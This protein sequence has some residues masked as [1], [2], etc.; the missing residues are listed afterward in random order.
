MTQI[1]ASVA[2]GLLLISIPYLQKRRKIVY[3]FLVFLASAFH[4][5]SILALTLCLFWIRRYDIKKVL[6]LTI[7]LCCVFSFFISPVV[8]RILD[9]IPF[10]PIRIKMAE[11]S[12]HDARFSLI[13]PQYV[14]RVL[15]YYFI[16]WKA[17]LIS[18]HNK[19]FY[20]LVFIDA[21]ALSIY[22]L[23]GAFPI[24]SGRGSE[25]LGVVEIILYP[26]AIYCFKQKSV[27]V[28]VVISIAVI[29]LI[30]NITVRPLISIS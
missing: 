21:V 30:G 10:E 22:P 4:Y 28:L 16:L 17:H 14:F 3:L 11:Y 25:L 8:F 23:F 27:G 29:F 1:R 26:L 12:L 24:I 6:W 15:L 20:T 7:P 5:S 2:A 19:Y 18:A 9:S 13:A